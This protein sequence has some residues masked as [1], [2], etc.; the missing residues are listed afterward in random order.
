[1]RRGTRPSPSEWLAVIY[2]V[3]LA[4]FF[5]IVAGSEAGSQRD[6]WRVF[7]VACVLGIA[8]PAIY[9][10]VLSR[11]GRLFLRDSEAVARNRRR[12]VMSTLIFGPAIAIVLAASLAAGGSAKLIA[13]AFF[14]GYVAGFI[15]ALLANFIRLW[16][17]P[18]TAR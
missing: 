8:G 3:S 11:R 2:P 5:L 9:S 18:R 13:S 6:G 10:L 7:G 16:R 12:M 1:M 4:C 17:E 15:P 14:G